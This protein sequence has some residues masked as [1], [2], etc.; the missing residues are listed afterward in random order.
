[1]ETKEQALAKAHGPNSRRTLDYSYTMKGILD[2]A[3]QP[4]FSD[5]QW[6]PLGALIDTDRFKRIGN[7]ME[8]VTWEQYVPLLT[9]WASATGWTFEVR[10]ITE[11]ADYAIVEMHEYAEYPDRNEAYNSVSVY[12]FGEDG[13]IVHL[14]I[15][16]QLKAPP[17]ANQAHQW[18]LEQV[19]ALP[20]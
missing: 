1:M 19:G 20:A 16:L 4:G 6:A 17:E 14:D 12:Q 3:K 5:E 18:K 13:K 10:R 11:G 2:D 8:V 9:A 15:Y 7:F